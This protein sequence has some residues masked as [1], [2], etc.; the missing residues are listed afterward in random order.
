MSVFKV[1]YLAQAPSVSL[2][3]P[4][5]VVGLGLV[6][7]V[8]RQTACL[9]A[10]TLEVGDCFPSRIMPL[11]LTNQPLLAVSFQFSYTFFDLL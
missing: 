1:A 5:P 10:P 2:S 6:P 11:V 3:H 8:A 4:P 9:E 7:P